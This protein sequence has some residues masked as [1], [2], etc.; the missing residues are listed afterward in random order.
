MEIY[1]SNN[2]QVAKYVHDDGSE[3]AIKTIPPGEIGCGGYGS[4][5]N[6]YNVFISTSV[7]CPVS[8]RFCYLTTKNCPYFKLSNDTII[9]N[10]ISAIKTELTYRPELK[11]M[12][13]KLS[14][15]GMGDGYFDTKQVYDVTIAVADILQN[16]A[17]SKGLDGVDIATT[18]PR[19][20][21][22]QE[23]YIRNLAF[24]IDS[25][26][27]NSKRDYYGKSSR[28]PVR[29]FYS[30]HSAFDETRKFLI[31]KTSDLKDALNY[32]LSL[33]RED[34]ISIIFHQMFFKGLNDDLREVAQ[35]IK[36]LDEFD[37]IELRL[38]R[39]N[40]CPGTIFEESDKF[41]YLVDYIYKYHDNIKVQTSPGAE[42][43]ASCGM[44]LLSKFSK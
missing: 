28:K 43:L 15:M 41:N 34:D 42:I 26:K 1:R 40:K 38:L 36:W 12:Y 32:L 20:P 29:V 8:C 37:N 17:L 30:L 14:W 33:Y 16:Q 35:V 10:I 3:T 39:F 27:L 44:F 2:G 11:K 4:I 18:L 19:I 9:S 7:G 23:D 6:K 21:T 24:T 22:K 13:T 25:Y 31:P 5:G